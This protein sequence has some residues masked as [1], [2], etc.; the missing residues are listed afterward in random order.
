MSETVHPEAFPEVD[1]PT[2]PVAAAV[3]AAGIG[4]FVLGLLT[5]LSE[6]STGVH[7]FLEF[8]D[9]V[10]PL[11]GKTILAVIAYFGSWGVLHAVWRRQNPA[12]RPIFIAAAVLVALGVLGTFPTFF[13]AFAS[14]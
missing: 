4:A 9:D 7:D 14:E 11:S 5:T 10:G 8:D 6:A 13:Q 3:F 1:R 2:G 12:L